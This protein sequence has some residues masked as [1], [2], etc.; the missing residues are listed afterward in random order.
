MVGVITLVVILVLVLIA[1]SSRN[2]NYRGGRQRFYPFSRHFYEKPS[3]GEDFEELI[4]HKLSKLEKAG[5]KVIRNCYLRWNNGTTTQIDDILIFRSGIYVIECK[6]YSGWIF[7]NGSH[8]NW[9]QTLPYGWYGDSTKISFYNP[10]KQNQNHIKCIRQNLHYNNSIPIH[11][12]VV[13]GDNCT[14]KNIENTLGAHVIKVDRLYEAVYRIEQ[15]TG[16]RLS[17]TEIDDIYSRIMQDV[18]ESPSIDGEHIRNVN[19]IKMQ[20]YMEKTSAGD[21]CPRC[22]SPLVLRNGHYGRFYGCVRYPSCKYT[23]KAD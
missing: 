1:I 13:F 5:A 2:N 10:I 7:G 4:E 6:D 11:N 9:T 14:F 21:T 22:G 15:E 20:K 8:E 16:P 23:R 12:I 18:S 17:E 3:D 19:R